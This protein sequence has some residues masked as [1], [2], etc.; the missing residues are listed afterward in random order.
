[1]QR[2]SM[3]VVFALLLVSARAQTAAPGN[4]LPEG[5]S[6]EIRV[7]FPNDNPIR[8]GNEVILAPRGT[9]RY[10]L[11]LPPGYHA[12][13]GKK[14]PCLFILGAGTNRPLGGVADRMIRDRWVVI[15]I[16]GT[17]TEPPGNTAA[18]FIA[19]HDDALQRVRIQPGLKCIMGSGENAR[20]GSLLAGMRHGFAGIICQNAFF[21]RWKDK[22][23]SGYHL[24]GLQQNTNLLIGCIVKGPGQAEMPDFLTAL[25]PW[26][27][28][29]FDT[30]E[31]GSAATDRILDWIE[32]QLFYSLPYD[33]A[34]SGFYEESFRSLSKQADAFRG[35]E[36]AD[37]LEEAVL[38]A[39][40]RKL[41]DD[42]RFRDQVI[43]L[44]GRL[45]GLK[46]Y[47]KEFEA[48]RLFNQIFESEFNRMKNGQH[49]APTRAEGF[50]QALSSLIRSYEALAARYPGTYY[51]KQ[52]VGRMNILSRLLR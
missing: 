38:L 40:Q 33:P 51:G 49:R 47:D 34:L 2:T 45:A 26:A 30:W 46:E 8:F 50:T 44:K 4:T 7:V 19:A 39:E 43:D 15:E 18:A 36:E 31:P 48:K 1:M 28:A 10:R 16:P 52:A 6:V 41:A 17:E 29:H 14:Y 37:R 35:F 27:K 32:Q 9:Y 23:Q 21:A 13:P 24:Q 42:T 22:D 3:I 20:R 12:N 25:P 5:K 11:F